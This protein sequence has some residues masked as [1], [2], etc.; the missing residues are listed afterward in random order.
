MIGPYTKNSYRAGGVA[1]L[2]ES[3]LST[4]DATVPSQAPYTTEC[5][6]EGACLR[7]RTWKDQKVTV[8]LTA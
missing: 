2:A 3:F 8:I 4:H 1:W 5:E 7:S 6:C